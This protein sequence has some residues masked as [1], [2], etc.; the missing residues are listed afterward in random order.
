ME[1][2]L[3]VA[4]GSAIGGVLRYELSTSVYRYVSQALPY[5]TLLVN[6]LGS[7]LAGFL[8]VFL[9]E[10]YEGVADQLRLILMVGFLGGFT[11]FS[12][13]S[14]ETVS[15]IYAGDWLKGL[16]NILLNVLLCLTCTALG[17]YLAKNG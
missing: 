9:L 15:L 17:G 5:G 3:L 1:R 2:W 12:A 4:L 16:F 10:H 8:W 14:V 13:F 7:F 11:T 6:V